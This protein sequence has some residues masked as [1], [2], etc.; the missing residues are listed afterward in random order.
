[1]QFLG[2][3]PSFDCRKILQSHVRKQAQVAAHPLFETCPAQFRPPPP[4]L[5]PAFCAQLFR[6]ALDS[7]SFP[8][9]KKNNFSP[10]DTPRPRKRSLCR[11]L[12]S[13]TRII[14]SVILDK[15]SS[16]PRTPL[17]VELET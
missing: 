16:N 11:Y 7:V 9:A 15:D 10:G 2:K 3:S 6:A 13:P 12:R 14:A 4:P 5:P 8:F 17:S 1:M